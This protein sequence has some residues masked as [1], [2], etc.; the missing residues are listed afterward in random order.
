MQFSS[1]S[2]AAF[3]SVLEDYSGKTITI[4]PDVDTN[5]TVFIYIEGA[6]NTV[7]REAGVE[8]DFDFRQDGNVIHVYAHQHHSPKTGFVTDRKNLVY[9]YEDDK[10]EGVLEFGEIDFGNGYY[11]LGQTKSGMFHGL[12]TLFNREG[13]PW[14]EGNWIEGKLNGQGRIHPDTERTDAFFAMAY[15]GGFKDNSLHGCGLQVT[16]KREFAYS[17]DDRT[18]K[19]LSG[20]MIYTSYKGLFNKWKKQGLGY[21]KEI[22]LSTNEIRPGVQVN[23]ML[24]HYSAISAPKTLVMAKDWN[25]S[26]AHS[27]E[28]EN[29]TNQ[30]RKCIDGE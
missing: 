19:T 29:I 20:N 4:E 18:A 15:S 9:K 28:L 24:E 23:Y 22:R 11:Y 25:V 17:D 14:L 16:G 12:G 10:K 8:H 3:F 7:L 6:L 2:L 27:S 13:Q 21:Q 1:I 5:Q 30:N 26:Y